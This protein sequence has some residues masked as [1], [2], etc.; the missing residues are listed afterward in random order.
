MSDYLSTHYFQSGFSAFPQAG[1]SNV[2]PA[3]YYA[4]NM[5]LDEESDH[6]DESYDESHGVVY[7][8]MDVDLDTDM[9]DASSY[10]SDTD[11][12]PAA[13][14][15]PVALLPPPPDPPAAPPPAP[16]KATWDN[17][18]PGPDFPITIMGDKYLYPENPTI[19]LYL[20][21]WGT[22]TQVPD[23]KR[24][25]VPDPA[26]TRNVPVSASNSNPFLT[27]GSNLTQSAGLPAVSQNKEVRNYVNK[28]KMKRPD[29]D[30][31]PLWAPIPKDPVFIGP[32]ATGSEGDDESE[33]SVIGSDAEDVFTDNE[34]DWETCSSDSSDDEE[35]EGSQSESESEAA[36][37]PA[38]PVKS[39]FERIK[40]PVETPAPTEAPVTPVKSLF[41]R[42]TFPA[43]TPAATETPEI[44]VKSLFDRITFPAAT[45]AETEVPS[46]GNSLFSR[47]KLPAAAPEEPADVVPTTAISTA[48]ST[49]LPQTSDTG[50]VD[51]K[52]ITPFHVSIPSTSIFTSA[53]LFPTSSAPA[54]PFNTTNFRFP[55]ST[56]NA[57][58]EDS[59]YGSFL[60]GGNSSG[61]P[62][63]FS[64]TFNYNDFNGLGGYDSYPP[65][66]TS[67]S[68]P[69]PYSHTS[70]SFPLPEVEDEMSELELSDS[71]ES[72]SVV[73]ALEYAK[74]TREKGGFTGVKGYWA[75]GLTFGD[76]VGPAKRKWEETEGMVEGQVK[77]RIAR[78]YGW[79][80]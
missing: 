32:P 53:P 63:N 25:F 15:L 3:V 77:R 57:G 44:P 64:N 70:P 46:F 71:E 51:Y 42:I 17:P 45:P 13:P 65:S 38:A 55:S 23:G 24:T 35:E 36:E 58:L 16:V 69:L 21:G 79:R 54:A 6:G 60:G 2:M 39:L 41:D 20:P 19:T 52:S 40:L 8:C 4:S 29:D 30:D 22:I 48:E 67:P 34:D 59:G 28:N 73:S 14:P 1:A 7:D 33:D 18:F 37:T 11:D 61:F 78:R 68:F 72:E 75:M 56:P 62:N 5:D 47:I 80:K 31:V 76:V 49:T 74:M 50:V 43:A 66:P 27:N 9:S 12:N 10:H 26:C